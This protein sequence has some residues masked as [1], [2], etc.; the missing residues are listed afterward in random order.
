MMLSRLL[1]LRKPYLESKYPS[2]LKILSHLD[3]VSYSQLILEVKSG[4]AWYLPL[5][6]TWDAQDFGDGLVLGKWTGGPHYK[7]DG[8]FDDEF[9]R[10]DL[11]SEVARGIVRYNHVVRDYVT[12]DHTSRLKKGLNDFLEFRIENSLVTEVEN[13]VGI[14]PRRMRTLFGFGFEE[15][16]YN[17]SPEYQAEVLHR[18]EKLELLLDK[19]CVTK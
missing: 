7:P 12:Q 13:S 9:D 3:T 2:A 17:I 10:C 18:G 8:F 14:R 6:T 4:K 11:V 5:D 16:E 19:Y 15:A 1:R